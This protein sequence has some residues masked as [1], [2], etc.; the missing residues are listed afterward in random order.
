M[1]HSQLPVLLCRLY[2]ASLSLVAKNIISL[3]L[4]LTIWW[5]PCVESSLV[6]LEKGVCYDQCIL[7]TNSVSLCLASF[8]CLRPTLP[9]IP[10]MSWLPTFAFQSRLMKR[11]SVFGVSTRRCCRSLWNLSSPAS[12][13]S[14]VGPYTS[15][16]VMLNGLPWK[17]T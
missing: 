6:L 13:E 2:W 15:I 11:T 3:T 4:V 10:G 8:C 5:C 16:I 1:S 14:V 12:S 7:W 17:Q 9:V